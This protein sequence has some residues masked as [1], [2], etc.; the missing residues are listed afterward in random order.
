MTTHANPALLKVENLSKVFRLHHGLF[1]STGPALTA[2]DNISFT[3]EAGQILGLVGES[4]SGKSTLGRAILQLIKPDSGRVLFRGQDLCRTDHRQLRRARKHI[5]V[6]FQDPLAALSPRRTIFQSLLEPLEQFDPENRPEH[7]QKCIDILATVGL[8]NSI[9]A[10]L[11]HQL[12]SGQRQRICIARAVLTEPELIIADEAV[13]ALD[14]SVQAQILELI[15]KLQSQRGIAFIFISHDLSVI[16]Q[17]ADHVGVMFQGQILESAP[18]ESLFSQPSHPYTRELLAAV[19]DPDPA[20]AMSVVDINTGLTRASRSACC[21]FADRCSRV[22]GKC[23]ETEPETLA[24][25]DNP[26]HYVK[27]HLYT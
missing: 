11:P 25:D 3:I 27:C 6:I 1:S 8:D 21:V 10:R 5:Q 19:P 26:G 16:P 24:L 17:V 4:G 14:V 13:S 9:L 18:V 22:M 7:R 20:V 15:R 23:R 2:I 12:S